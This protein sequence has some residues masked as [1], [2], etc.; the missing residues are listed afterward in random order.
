MPPSAEIAVV[1]LFEISVVRD[2]LERESVVALDTFLWVLDQ[3]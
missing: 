2:I 3:Q 1:D